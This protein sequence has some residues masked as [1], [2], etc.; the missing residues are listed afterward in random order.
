MRARARSRAN[1]CLNPGM[2]SEDESMK[3]RTTPAASPYFMRSRS[4][5]ASEEVRPEAKTDSVRSARAKVTARKLYSR[6]LSKSD[7]QWALG[8]A[9]DPEDDSSSMSSLSDVEP[10][11]ES[12]EADQKPLVSSGRSKADN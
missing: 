7:M 3:K 2:K 5:A 8:E 10:E 1:S 4:N 6:R 11:S 9:W 12:N